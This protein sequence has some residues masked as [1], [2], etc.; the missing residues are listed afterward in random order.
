MIGL[1]VSI[2]TFN[3]LAYRNRSNL[4]SNQVLH[5]WSFTIAFQ[6]IFDLVVE[7]K[8]QGYWY[9]TPGVDLGG[10]L[11]HTVLIPPVNV[12]F[13][14]G[15]PVNRSFLNKAVYLIIWVF[16]I[17]IY[18][19]VVL[20]PEPW[21]YFHYGWWTFWHSLVIDPILFLILLGYFRW[22]VHL[23]KSLQKKA[24]SS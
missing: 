17:L 24:T 8:Y 23:E 1:I 2:L 14:N 19:Y 10:L 4:T 21:G 22:V 20:F 18:E 3:L 7:F 11:T 9:F 12:L 15:Y 16:G 13:L 5:I 6:A